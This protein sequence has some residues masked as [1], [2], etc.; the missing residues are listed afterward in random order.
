LGNP[1][2]ERIKIEEQEFLGSRSSEIA[3]AR[4]KVERER[5]IQRLG[6]SIA[7]V[8]DGALHSAFEAAKRDA[9]A[10]SEFARH[11][12]RFDLT[13]VGNVNTYAHS[14]RCSCG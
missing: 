1:P 6:S 12:G 9:E 10:A 5:L 2:W 11:S 13:A 8:A 3:L 4:N 14:A 7:S